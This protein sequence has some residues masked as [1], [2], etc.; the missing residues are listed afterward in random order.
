M[1]KILTREETARKEKR[2]NQIL[3]IVLLLIMVGSTAGFAFFSR[4]DGSSSGGKDKVVP[5]GD[6]W[7]TYIDDQP[8]IF[9]NPPDVLND[10]SVIL[11]STI[12]QFSGKPLYIVS[13]SNAFYGE[14]YSSLGRYAARVQNACYS[15]CE[16][17]T[18][19]EKTCADNLIVI[20]PAEK[21]KVY[22]NQSC[23]FIEGDMRAVDAFLYRVL[24]IA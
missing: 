12:G 23:I 24:G 21:N 3:S 11:L 19:V 9:S 4:S 5:Y 14:I 10:T 22:Q 13:D 16:N 1:R 7:A 2:R 8:I 20:K 15:S 6:K 17:S 18:L